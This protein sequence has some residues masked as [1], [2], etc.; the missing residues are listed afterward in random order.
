MHPED[1]DG[2]AKAVEAFLVPRAA[3]QGEP[4]DSR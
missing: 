3:A 2:I 1:E 4:D